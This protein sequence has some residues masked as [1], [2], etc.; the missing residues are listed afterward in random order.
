MRPSQE[1]EDILSRMEGM[2]PGDR[3]DYHGVEIRKGHFLKLW[4]VGIPNSQP[5]SQHRNPVTAAQKARRLLKQLKK[6]RRM[7]E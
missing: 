1:L 6:R 4:L 7:L 5:Y 2:Y 3:L